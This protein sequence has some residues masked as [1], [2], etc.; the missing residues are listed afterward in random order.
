MNIVQANTLAPP[1]NLD[2]VDS[3]T[4]E[5]TYSYEPSYAIM[6]SVS[7][8]NLIQMV[9]RFQ[10]S[11]LVTS[12]D[13]PHVTLT[14]FTETDRLLSHQSILTHSSVITIERSQSS[15]QTIQQ[16][17]AANTETATTTKK[18]RGRPA[19]TEQ[20]KLDNAAKKQRK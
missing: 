8:N 18:K 11:N 2:D 12:T 15:T 17:E 9:D 13:V 19:L 5:P 14:E 3:N 6:T 1:P 20:Q 7:S 4:G 10:A 16:Q